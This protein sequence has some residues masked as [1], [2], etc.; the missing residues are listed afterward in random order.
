[1][2]G[3]PHVAVWVADAP[4]ALLPIL[5]AAALDVA[6]EQF[7]E[8]AAIRREVFVRLADLP[9]HDSIRDLRQY[10]LNKLVRV[11]GV[12]TRRTGV[13]PMLQL[14]KYDCVKCRYLLGPFAQA[15]DGGT[16]K[17]GSC[18]QCQSKGPFT[19]NSAE[20]L[21]Q[22]YQKITVQEA[23]GSVPPGPPPA[24]EGCD[25]APRPHRR[26]QAGRARRRHGRLHA[27][28]RRLAQRAPRLPGL[29]DAARGQP[30]REALRGR[31]RRRA[32]WR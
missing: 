18:P 5:H 2:H 29:R 12:A 6:L 25:P 19:V 30:R 3:A 23:P 32:R 22:N 14:V 13:F 27:R 10:H 21:Y 24:A 17:L 9:I 4:G 28:L 8:F 26:G 15:D 7:P 20:T 31:R 1:M 16:I 11:S